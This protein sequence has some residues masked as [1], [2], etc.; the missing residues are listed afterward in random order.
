[1]GMGEVAYSG[2]GLGRGS[3]GCRCGEG[4]REGGVWG[5]IGVRRRRGVY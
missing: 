3:R 5:V 4:A 2:S 1:M